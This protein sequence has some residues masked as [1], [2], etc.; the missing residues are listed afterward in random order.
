MKFGARGISRMVAAI[1][2]IVI[3][4]VAAFGVYF[5]F[6]MQ[7]PAKPKVLG[8]ILQTHG[9]RGSTSEVLRASGFLDGVMGKPL[10]PTKGKVIT[11]DPSDVETWLKWKVEAYTDIWKSDK[12]PLRAGRTPYIGYL[13]LG[14][15]NPWDE[16]NLAS[17]KWYCGDVLGWR[18]E[19]AWPDADV[20]K[21]NDMAAELIA[22]GVDAIV[23]CPLDSMAN[24]KIGELAQKAGIP[25]VCFGIDMYHRW[26]LAFVQRDDYESG[27][28]C[29]KYVRDKL[30]EKFGPDIKIGENILI[31]DVGN[32][33]DAEAEFKYVKAAMAANP[34]IVAVFEVMGGY[35]EAW[36]RAAKDLGWSEQKIKDIIAVDVD[37]FPVNLDGYINGYQDYCRMMPTAGYMI[38]ECLEILKQFWKYGPDGL[39]NIGEIYSVSK[40]VPELQKNAVV[41][42]TNFA[43]LQW[44]ED[45]VAGVVGYTIR[46]STC[47][48]AYTP[49]ILIPDRVVTAENYK[50]PW[51]YWNWPVWGY[52]HR[53]EILR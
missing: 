27:W 35:H 9:Y 41:P 12:N 4:I 11:V 13:P 22:K 33:W 5:Y 23:V 25:I 10:P 3:I 1:I 53:P 8:Y 40:H 42:G 45:P 37:F 24:A 50:S 19:V 43:P 15:Y 6:A 48:G 20:K 29:G 31:V 14:I 16:L 39:P 34:D 49:W 47:G 28:Y 26:P 52:P 46:P 30:I 36:V 44:Y 32:S 2:A 21:Q 51:I 18:Y 38:A 7:Q 17:F